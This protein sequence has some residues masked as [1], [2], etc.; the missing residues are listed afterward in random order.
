MDSKKTKVQ[1]SQ[2]LPQFEKEKA[3]FVV[4]G[5]Q[6]GKF[7]LAHK[8]FFPLFVPLRLTILNIQTK[9]AIL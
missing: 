8:G 2:K 6:E 4:T 9:R 3:L 7:F 5:R 1:I